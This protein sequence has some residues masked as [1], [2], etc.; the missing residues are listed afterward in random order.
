MNLTHEQLLNNLQWLW[1]KNILSEAEF[2][3]LK[4]NLKSKPKSF[5]SMGFKFDAGTN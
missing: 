5:G 2:D 3:E 1:S 4:D